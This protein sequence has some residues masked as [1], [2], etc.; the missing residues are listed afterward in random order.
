VHKI[1][2]RPALRYGIADRGRLIPGTYA[3]VT[4]FDMNTIDS[5]AT[6]ENPNLPPIGI[7]YVFRNGLPLAGGAVTQQVITV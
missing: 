4:V 2:S 1:T 7:H 6:Y 5:L 3:D